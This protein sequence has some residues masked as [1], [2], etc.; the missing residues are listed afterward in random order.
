M[1]EINQKWLKSIENDKI[2]ENSQYIYVIFDL[3]HFKGD[4]F[5]S[6]LINFE[7]SIEIGQLLI[8]FVAMIR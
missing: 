2:N 8:N 3:F 1:V 7:S 4:Y 5:Q 6:F